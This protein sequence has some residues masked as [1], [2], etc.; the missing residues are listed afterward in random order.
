MPG[1]GEEE[2]EIEM[3]RRRRSY[4]RGQTVR[5]GVRK[6]WELRGCRGAANGATTNLFI[7]TVGLSGPPATNAQI[8]RVAF[9]GG[10][11]VKQSLSNQ[12]P[13]PRERFDEWLIDVY[14]CVLLFLPLFF[15]FLQCHKNHLPLDGC[16]QGDL[17]LYLHLVSCRITKYKTGTSVTIQIR[18]CVW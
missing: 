15:F 1:G 5:D 17:Q 8:P 11:K 7:L 13:P 12:H 2:E 10:F 9:G 6:C 4:K 3:C 14:E 16:C 18:Y